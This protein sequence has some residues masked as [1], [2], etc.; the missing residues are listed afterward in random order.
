MSD[1]PSHQ[2]AL[3]KWQVTFP[4][5]GEN[6]PDPDR[7]HLADDTYRETV[8]ELRVRARFVSNIYRLEA[9]KTLGLNGTTFTVSIPFGYARKHQC[10]MQSMRSFSAP[11]LEEL[12]AE[13]LDWFDGLDDMDWITRG[14]YFNARPRPRERIFAIRSDTPT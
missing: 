7:W 9:G 8:R 1:T 12:Q 2:R 10:G 4:P 11:S 13:V 14:G 6:N 5:V 3:E